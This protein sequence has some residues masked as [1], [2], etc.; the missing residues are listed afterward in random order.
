MSKSISIYENKFCPF[1]F[2]ELIMLI[3]SKGY[4]SEDFSMSIKVKDKDCIIV[5]YSDDIVE[6]IDDKRLLR[7]GF[8]RIEEYIFK[9]WENK[10]N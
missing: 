1:D 3:E 8:N 4:E 10:E 7:G 9:S 2:I 6:L 5:F